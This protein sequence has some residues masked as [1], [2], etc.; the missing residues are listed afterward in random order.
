MLEKAI[1]FPLP[2]ENI[3]LLPGNHAITL[4]N[5][6]CSLPSSTIPQCLQE[7]N[8]TIRSQHKH[9]RTVL[10]PGRNSYILKEL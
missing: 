10:G 8:K 4:R 2:K 7:K 3:I 5:N 6:D 9:R 1:P